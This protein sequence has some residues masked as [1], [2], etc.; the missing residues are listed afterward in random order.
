MKEQTLEWFKN[1]YRLSGLHSQPTGYMKFEDKTEEVFKDVELL[2]NKT[3][4]ETI[5]GVEEILSYDFS[6][7]TYE[8]MFKITFKSLKELLNKLKK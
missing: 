1:K 4:E 3:R 8:E 6:D 2:I 5:R 7:N